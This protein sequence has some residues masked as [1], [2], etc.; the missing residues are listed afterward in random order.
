M[1]KPKSRA[2][3]RKFFAEAGKGKKWAKKA[4]GKLKKGD[5][6][7]LPAKSKRKK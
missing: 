1:P 6:K 3:A 2:Q 5:V 4:V 7:R